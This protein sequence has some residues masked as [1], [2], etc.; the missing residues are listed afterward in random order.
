V[1]DSS[2]FVPRTVEWVSASILIL[3]GVANA[4]HD[5]V[6]AQWRRDAENYFVLQA[7]GEPEW[8]L[9]VHDNWAALERIPQYRALVA[10]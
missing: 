10:A 8:G 6:F 1:S 4:P 2:G 3:R 7:T 5:D 9:L